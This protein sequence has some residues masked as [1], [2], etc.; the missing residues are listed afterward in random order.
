MSHVTS[1]QTPTDPSRQEALAA[2]EE[3]P[4]VKSA[5]KAKLERELAE[6][7]S[8]PRTRLG[9]IPTPQHL[10]S[11]GPMRT[12]STRTVDHRAI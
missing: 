7:A 10:A 5:L 2:Q 11:P 1:H 12:S 9:G 3:R 4:A 6:D 8:T